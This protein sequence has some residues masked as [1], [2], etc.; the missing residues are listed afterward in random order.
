MLLI[1]RVFC[2]LLLVGSGAY[3]LYYRLYFIVTRLIFKIH[4]LTAWYM[5]LPFSLGTVLTTTLDLPFPYT[6]GQI[7]FHG[8]LAWIVFCLFPSKLCYEC[9]ELFSYIIYKLYTFCSNFGRVSSGVITKI[10]EIWQNIL[11]LEYKI[12]TGLGW[13][14][15][16]RCTC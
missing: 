11:L 15:S 16:T 13:G 9:Y 2:H 1:F 12:I 3:L 5:Y 14:T 7:N 8:N 10:A 6:K 4:L